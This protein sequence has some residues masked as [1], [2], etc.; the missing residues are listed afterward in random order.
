MNHDKMENVVKVV[1][2]ILF[3]E[4]TVIYVDGKGIGK[5]TLQVHAWKIKG[6][7]YSIHDIC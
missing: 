7:A 6:E 2:F 1:E 5:C 3:R 4:S